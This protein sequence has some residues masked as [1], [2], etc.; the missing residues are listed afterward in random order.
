MDLRSLGYLTPVA[1]RDIRS[2]GFLDASV[3]FLDDETLAVSFL[4]ANEHP[5]PSKRDAPMGSP[6]LFHT[7][8]LNALNGQLYKQRSWGNAGNWQVFLPLRNSRFFV[9]DGDQIAVYSKDLEEITTARIHLTGDLYPR[10]AV[11]PSGETL[12][13][14]SDSYDRKNG[15]LTRIDII[16][17]GHLTSKPWTFTVGHRFETVS[18]ARVIFALALQPSAPLHLFVQRIDQ[19]APSET[20]ELFA[21]QQDTAKA[22]AGSGCDSATFV[23]DSVLAISGN[24]AHLFLVR[25]GEITQEISA[26]AYRFGSD[27]RASR[28]GN[29]FAFSRSQSISN[30][31]RIFNLEV[32]VYDIERKR[33]IFTVP[34]NPLPQHKLGFALSPD[35]SLVALQ[36][37]NLL[38]VWSLPD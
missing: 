14:F 21:P 3:A 31:D 20:R 23:S 2:L 7:A 29:R 37:D 10:F 12:F 26:P 4:V 27:F 33:I 28:R 15:W 18:D 17:A 6:V 35:G 36:S 8:L 9:Q 5:G 11:S 16:D 38:R 22:I 34:V 24:C 13:S 25:A 19:P 32:C 1:E 30:T